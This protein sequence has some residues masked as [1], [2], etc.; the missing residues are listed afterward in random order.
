MTTTNKDV[1]RVRNLGI[2]AFVLFI[3]A[4]LLG[5][6][7]QFQKAAGLQNDVRSRDERI[8]SLEREANLSRGRELASH[9]Y[10]ELTRKNFGVAGQHAT[11]FF[12]HIRQITNDAAYSALRGDL[13]TILTQ[14]DL[15]TANI[16]K[17]DPAAEAQVREILERLHQ[18][19]AR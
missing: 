3:V 2:A 19:T 12:N 6:V 9:L 16:A 5:F 13:D 1:H 7:P 18:M 14:R 8:A 15:V 17:S 11:Q 10:L 4:F